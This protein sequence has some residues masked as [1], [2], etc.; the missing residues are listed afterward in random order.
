MCTTLVHLVAGFD[1]LVDHEGLRRYTQAEVSCSGLGFYTQAPDI[2]R[3]VYVGVCFVSATQALEDRL[4]VLELEGE[5]VSVGT[6]GSVAVSDQRVPE[7]SHLKHA[8]FQPA[9][10]GF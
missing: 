9:V 1:A 4:G 7:M 10:A 5:G 6:A 2:F 8:G 3:C